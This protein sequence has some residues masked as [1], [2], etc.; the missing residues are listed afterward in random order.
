MDSRIASSGCQGSA[1]TAGA[2]RLARPREGARMASETSKPAGRIQDRVALITGG[3][4]GIGKAT[5][6]LFLAEGAKVVIADR[7]AESLDQ[8]VK[9]LR[10]VGEHGDEL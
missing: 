4:S 10:Q 6:Q 9:D 7:N 3:A 2:T 8:A 1:V 5:A